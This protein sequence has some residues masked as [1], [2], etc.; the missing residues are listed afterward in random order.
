MAKF[1]CVNLGCDNFDKE[2][3][4]NKIKWIFNK[5]S[6]NLEPDPPVICEVCQ[7]PLVFIK[8]NKGMCVNIGKFNSMNERDKKSMLT[9]RAKTHLSKRQKEEKQHY[10]EQAI[11]N[12][13]KNGQ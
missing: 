2:I 12:Y 9:K 3:H 10:K 11:K 6:K 5:L 4:F 1:K 7:N 8:E 13:F